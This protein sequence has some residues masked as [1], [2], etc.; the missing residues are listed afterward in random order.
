LE[1]IEAAQNEVDLVELL[2]T[3]EVIERLKL[4]PWIDLY[5]LI[6]K[7]EALFVDANRFKEQLF[8]LLVDP[9][10]TAA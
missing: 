1:C 9:L 4:K 10:L 3:A 6:I 2:Y 8:V 5:Y 7:N